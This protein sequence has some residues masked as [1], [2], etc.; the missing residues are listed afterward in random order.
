MSSEMNGLSAMKMK[1]LQYSVFFGEWESNE[2]P[3]NGGGV[4]LN[5][6]VLRVNTDIF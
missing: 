5:Y 6:F 1:W 3:C 4:Y 2:H